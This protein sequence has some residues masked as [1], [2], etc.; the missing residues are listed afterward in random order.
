MTK[1]YQ[2]FESYPLFYQPYIPPV[3]EQL[4]QEIDSKVVAFKGQV[5]TGEKASVLPSY[6]Y[7][8][9]YEKFNQKLNK[10][11]KN[12]NYLEILA[13]QQKVDIIHLQHS[14][15]FNKVK[16]LLDRKR[17]DRPKIIISLRGGD[18][19]IKP[20]T[21]KRWKDFYQNYGDQ[22]DAFVVMSHDQKS[23][24]HRWGVPLERIHVIP[25]SF[26][27]KF[28]V[29]PKYPNRDTLKIVSVFRM[30]WEKNI[31]DNLRLIKQIKQ[32]GINVMYD[33]YGDG[34]DIGQLYYLLDRYNLND[35]V[36]VKGKVENSILKNKL[37][38]YDF[39]LQLSHSESFGMSVVEAQ[40]FG[41]PAIVSNYGGLQEIILNNK[42]GIISENLDFEKTCTC[43]VN[44]WQNKH[45]YFE[46]S[47]RSIMNSQN[48]YNLG[49]EVKKLKNLYDS[50]IL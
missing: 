1:V 8:R 4:S 33:V 31:A 35:C 25:I 49:V 47:H 27:Q 18:T 10:K 6:T 50:I 29:Q 48:K 15:L 26:G 13:I 3:L 9:I 43:I 2:V 21:S 16:N 30:C 20:W 40:I 23:Y 34:K 24:L 22:V 46:Y 19:Y 32:T 14:Y 36:N 11:Y 41:V 39:I 42:T 45:I 5:K 17:E 37:K 12:L 7:R 38:D 44:V 28:E